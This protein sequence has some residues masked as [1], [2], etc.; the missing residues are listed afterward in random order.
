MN[1]LV[2]VPSENPGGLNAQV[3]AHFGHC[4]MFT[5]IQVKDD[6]ILDVKTIPN[7]PHEQGGCLAPVNHL[8]EQGIHAIIAG[9]MGMRPLMGFKQMGIKVYYSD[10]NQTVGDA[11]DAFLAG[12]LSQFSELNTCGG[13]KIQN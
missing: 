6:Q 5:L 2:A 8:S 3:G 11:I 10:E 1:T 7:V 9:G 12:R 4:E 13:G